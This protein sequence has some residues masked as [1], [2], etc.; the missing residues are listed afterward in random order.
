MILVYES[1]TSAAVCLE[2]REQ[3]GK[4]QNYTMPVLYLRRFLQKGE[5]GRTQWIL[6]EVWQIYSTG[7]RTAPEQEEAEDGWVEEKRNRLKIH[8]K[9]IKS[10]IL[11]EKIILLTYA[12]G[13]KQPALKSGEPSG[14]WVRILPS[15]LGICDSYFCIFRAY[16][17]KL[18]LKEESLRARY[19]F[20]TV[21]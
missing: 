5:G 4:G 3:D 21:A 12:S 7:E 16:G 8:F 2:R 15:A 18:W 6:P 17:L 14:P 20:G 19:S 13:H 10:V 1:C 11:I 9:K